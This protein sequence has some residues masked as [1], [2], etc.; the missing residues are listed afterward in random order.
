MAKDVPVWTPGWQ[1]GV[2]RGFQ[3]C[4]SHSAQQQ[5]SGTIPGFSAEMVK[6]RWD[7]SHR[8]HPQSL[9]LCLNL[10]HQL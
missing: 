2:G 7:I 9:I 10:S 6:D 8:A 4:V 5:L 3:V 1:R